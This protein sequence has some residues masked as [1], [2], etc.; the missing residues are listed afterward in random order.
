MVKY[1]LRI[2]DEKGRPEQWSENVRGAQ[3]LP[4]IGESYPLNR[5]GSEAGVNYKVKDVIHDNYIPQEKQRKGKNLIVVM[6]EPIVVLQ[7]VSE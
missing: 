4:R 6:K 3:V 2:C 1:Y 7:R 5:K